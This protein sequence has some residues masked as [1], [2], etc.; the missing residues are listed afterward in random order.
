[1]TH[2]AYNSFAIIAALFITVVTF[3]QALTMPAQAAAPIVEIA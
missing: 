1:M 3:N 2:Y